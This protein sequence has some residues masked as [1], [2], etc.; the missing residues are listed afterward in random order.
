MST[1]ID[2]INSLVIVF[3]YLYIYIFKGTTKP[4]M[5]RFAGIYLRA[6]VQFLRV[7]AHYLRAFVQFLRVFAY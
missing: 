1:N 6:F 4:V 3:I 2:N 5:T 7:F